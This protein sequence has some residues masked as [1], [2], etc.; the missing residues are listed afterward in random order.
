MGSAQ[1]MNR[2]PGTISPDLLELA[3]AYSDYSVVVTTAEVDQPGPQILYVNSMFTRMT[4][5]ALTDVL[6]KTP[7]ILQGP[8]TSRDVLDELR[9][10]LKTGTD[11]V[12]RAINYKRDGTPFELEWHVHPLKDH[13]GNIT[14]FLA[15]QR[16]TT[17]QQRSAHELRAIDAELRAARTKLMDG[18]SRLQLTQAKQAELDQLNMLARTSAGVL[19]DLSN[20]LTPLFGFIDLIGTRKDVP[21]SVREQAEGLQPAIEFAVEVLANLKKHYQS[22][23]GNLEMENRPVELNDLLRRAASV[24]QTLQP[25][26]QNSQAAPVDVTLNLAAPAAVPGNE[27]ELLQLFVN[28]IMNALHAMAD[29]GELTIDVDS[30]GGSVVVTIADTGPGMTPEMLERCFEPYVS[31]RA[32]GTGLG[33]SVCRRIVESHNGT[34]E[35]SLRDTG[36]VLCTVTLP[37]QHADTEVSHARGLRAL[38]MRASGSRELTEQAAKLGMSFED[39]GSCDAGLERLAKGSYD[40]TIVDEPMQPTPGHHIAANLKRA[41]PNMAIIIRLGPDPTQAAAGAFNADAWVPADVSASELAQ[42]LRGLL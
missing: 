11:F 31:T 42:T 33:L 15:V 8:E 29:G 39:V 30:A 38:H 26:L 14:H 17:N 37:A 16:D 10:A 40:L 34:I 28:L 9:T 24:A 12:G 13:N 4:G 32:A 20:S 27:T 7:R 25:Q 3:T 21:E 1:A 23:S 41:Y 5:Y 22:N 6:G 36:G 35:M 19:H 18:A 2:T